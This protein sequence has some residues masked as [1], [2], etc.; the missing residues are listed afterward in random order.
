MGNLV[1]RA[2]LGGTTSLSGPNTAATNVLLVPNASGNLAWSSSALTAT[3]V[4]YVGTGGLLQ[5]SSAFTFDGTTLSAT[6]VAGALNGTLGATTPASAS[7]TSLTNAGLTAGRVTYATTSG[8]L[9]DSANLTFSGTSLTVSNDVNLTTGS[10]KLA[11][12]YQLQWYTGATQ[13]GSV[14]CDTSSNLTFQTG[15]SNTERARIDSSGNLLIGTTSVYGINSLNVLSL[16]TGGCAF[17]KGSN[18]P[19]YDVVSIQGTGTGTNYMM[20]FRTGASGTGTQVGGITSTASATAY[21]TSSD[22]RLKDNIQPMIGAL[23][24][25]NALKPVTYDWKIGGASQ[26]FIAHELQEVCPQAVIGEKDAVDSEGNPKYQGIDTSFLVA[27]L[28][29][30]IQELNAK[31][32]GLEEQILNLG[33]K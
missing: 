1:F 26:G 12:T 23:D 11:G 4:P 19:T 33:V 28:T 6:K 29:A 25:V 13:L 22:Y 5:D 20:A 27:T 7:V 32:T 16:S 3:R 24:K 14:L 31:V 17:F 8:L 15:S 10:V 21:A 30:A 2:T 9:T 18:A